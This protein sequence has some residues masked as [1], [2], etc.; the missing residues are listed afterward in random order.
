[1]GVTT[2]AL[3]DHD[4]LEGIVEAQQ[5]AM[6][7]DIDLIPGVELSLE[8][9]TPGGM[10]L[11]VLWLEPGEGP[12]QVRLNE[13]Q[14]G[15]S[16][17]NDRILER[18]DD[19]GMPLTLEEVLVEAGEGSVGR[20]HIAKVMVDHGYVP[21]IKTAFDLWLGNDKP[22]YAGRPRLEPAEA[23]ALARKSGGDPGAGSHPTPWAAH[24]S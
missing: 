23:V 19:L 2:L 5:A 3:T 20:P 8:T 9:D 17:R 4:T 1:M 18:L 13:L 14:S 22:A 21:D 7:H 6:S 24:S 10:H 16:G 11:L 12:L 15:R